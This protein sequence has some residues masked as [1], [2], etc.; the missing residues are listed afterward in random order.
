MNDILNFYDVKRNNFHLLLYFNI[1]NDKYGVL[2]NYL[3]FM[4]QKKN[5][6]IFFYLFNFY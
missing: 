1:Y 5:S 4:N 2:E 6:F 3:L